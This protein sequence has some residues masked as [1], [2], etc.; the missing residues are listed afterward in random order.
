MISNMLLSFLFL[1]LLSLLYLLPK[2][3]KKKSKFNPPGPP[4]LP[5]IGNLHQ[6]DQS[7]LHSS[8]WN[9]TKPYG[10]IVSL[11]FGFNSAVVISSASLAKD[12]LKTQDLIFC[13]R[14]LFIGQQKIT[15]DGIDIA[16]SPYSKCWRE[17]R[18][19]FTHHLF[20]PK[21]VRSFRCIREDE[22]SSAMKTIHDLALSSKPVNLSE[23]MKSVTSN[24][25]MRVSFGKRYQH[26]H[27]STKVFG[28]LNELQAYL[29]DLYFSDVWPGLPFVGLVD[30]LMGK[31][32]RLEKCFQDLDSFYQQ[33]I[34]ERLINNQKRKSYEEDKDEDDVMDILLQLVKDKLFS[35]TNEHIKAMLMDV[36]VAGTDT[37][38]AIV[39]WA[40]TLLI[41]NP[42]VM[43]KAQEEV[44]HVIGKNSKID[45]DDLTKLTYLKAVIKETTRLYPPVPLLVPRETR[46]DSIVH[47]YKIK[48]KTL[49]Y[50][51]AW[52][53]GRDPRSWERPEEFLPERFL[54]S[55]DIDFKGN[56]FELIPFGAGRRL[57]PGMSIGVV[58]VELLLANLLYLFNWGLPDG[59]GKED[60]DFDAMPGIT[61]H[62]KN[63]LCVLAHLQF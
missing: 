24:I 11:R 51:N 9:L 50:V 46:K 3:I 35:L 25:M 49:V 16:F 31:M 40:M 27:E 2:I 36:L 17:M 7:S 37:S 20:S 21:R 43:K 19:I 18:K 32:N 34:D 60:I 58:M 39:V 22:V 41:R 54:G 5:F 1:P 14:P 59:V 53:I 47:G 33:L 15:Y 29:V 10:P 42:K 13:D 8:L 28:L 38:A 52:A 45:E 44:R 56:D 23:M 30:R 62:K 61:M 55:C 26:G 12:V 48:Q 57:C 63:E 4:G 6:I